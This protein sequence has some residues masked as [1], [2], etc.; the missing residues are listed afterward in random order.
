M[1]DPYTPYETG[2]SAFLNRVDKDWSHYVDVLTLEARLRENLDK[3]RKYGDTAQL[4]HER[5]QILAN[6]NRL[7]LDALGTS[8][9]ALSG[10]TD[11][12]VHPTSSG[13]LP[14]KPYLVLVGRD[15]EIVDIMTALRDPSGHFLSIAIDGMGGIGKTALAYEV[16]D[17]CLGQGLF[18]DVVWASA[19]GEEFA[20]RRIRQKFVDSMTLESVL[21][22]VGRQLG[23]FGILGLKGG[24]KAKAVREL[25]SDRRVLI[26]LDNM[27]TAEEPQDKILFNLSMMLNPSKALLTS[28]HRFGDLPSLQIHLTG[29]SEEAGILLMRQVATSK[30]IQRVVQASDSE[31][32]QVVRRTGGSPLAMQ[33]VTGLLQHLPLKQI[34]DQLE[35]VPPPIGEKD[36]VTY[37]EFYRFIYY[38]SWQLISDGAQ[39]LVATLTLWPA[40]EGASYDAIQGTSGLDEQF[41]LHYI[42]ELWRHSFVE[43]AQTANLQRPRYYLHPLTHYFVESDI[44][45]LWK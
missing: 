1:S 12:V 5:A 23:A 43:A 35:T 42:D 16:A 13:K 29:L 41:L 45:E 36:D 40:N 44:L 10:T 19:K 8:F 27:E 33:L 31:L 38:R 32:R 24:E 30:H 15:K 34:L 11:Q 18:E 26:V 20:E 4:Q 6:L 2:L 25:L 21:D 14:N 9:N 39:K 37:Y 22:T 17:L 3:T 28:R 7:T